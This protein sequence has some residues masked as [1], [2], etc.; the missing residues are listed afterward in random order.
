[1]TRVALTLKISL[2][3]L[4]TNEVNQYYILKRNTQIYYILKQNIQMTRAALT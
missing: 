4:R 3:K 1:M 2:P